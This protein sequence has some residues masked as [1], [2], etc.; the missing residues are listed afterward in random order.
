MRSCVFIATTG[1]A[2]LFAKEKK[3]EKEAPPPAEA[4]G[5][6]AVK[7]PHAADHGGPLPLEEAILTTAPEVPPPLKRRHRARVRVHLT[8]EVKDIQVCN[9][10]KYRAWTFNGSVP[11]PFIR[12]RVGDILEVHHTNKDMSGMPH[13][14]DFHAVKG[15]GGGGPLTL[16][17]SGQTKIASFAMQRPGLFVYHCAAAP[18]PVH[19]ANGMYGLILVEPEW[20]L[21]AVDK[22]YYVMQNEW[23]PAHD[24]K[25]GDVVT[26]CDYAA[27]LDEKPELVVFNG[28]EGSM[29]TKPLV[30]KVDDR[31]RLFV[32]NAGPN[33]ISS[34]HVIGGVFGRVYREGDLL[35]EPARWVQTTLV[36]AG[37]SAVVE[38]HPNVP[39]TYTIVDHSIF[40]IDKGAVGFINVIGK[41]QPQLF[42]SDSPAKACEGCK[43]HP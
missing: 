17:E 40:R 35:T 4:T 38:M 1:F 27:G 15:P 33:L 22:E 36:P 25:E 20:G 30:A 23:Y 31:V 26:E 24:S 7:G 3:A 11:G 6:G 9:R 37:G 39:G 42:G 34:F 5:E 2:W 8:S 13:N 12:V 28:K 10:Y 21:P 32:G 18:V 29:V 43:L 16:A 41:E 19:I 14:V